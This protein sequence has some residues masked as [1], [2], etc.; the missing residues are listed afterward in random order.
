MRA[1]RAKKLRAFVLKYCCLR[2]L[3][4][5]PSKIVDCTQE[6]L[7][8]SKKVL[9]NF[10]ASEAS[11]KNCKVFKVISAILVLGRNFKAHLMSF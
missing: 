7:Y 9:Y 2:A 6:N 5:F 11:E 10:I 1:K 8:T 4:D 3:L